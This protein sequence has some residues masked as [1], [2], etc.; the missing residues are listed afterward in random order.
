MQKPVINDNT[1]TFLKKLKE[2]Y[3]QALIAEDIYNQQR[4]KLVSKL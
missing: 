1:Y 3:N 2:A 4:E